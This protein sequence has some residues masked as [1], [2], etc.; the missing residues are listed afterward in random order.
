MVGVVLAVTVAV[1]AELDTAGGG[2]QRL[3]GGT[4]GPGR[5]SGGGGAVES[6][7]ITTGLE[8]PARSVSA[9]EPATTGVE[10]VTVARRRLPRVPT[11]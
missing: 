9:D 10:P 11:P 8:E 6:E 2:Q 5:S 7:T 4:Q 3:G 1:G